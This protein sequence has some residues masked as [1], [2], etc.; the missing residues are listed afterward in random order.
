[1]I[2]YCFCC[3]SL[4]LLM[5]ML[6]WFQ[7]TL[8][9]SVVK[10]LLF[11]LL[12]VIFCKYSDV[13]KAARFPEPAIYSCDLENKF[14]VYPAASGTDGH[15]KYKFHMYTHSRHM[16]THSRHMYTHS[17][18]RSDGSL[19]ASE[20]LAVGISSVRDSTPA[21]LFFCS[22]LDVSQP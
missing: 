10:F 3:P 16:Y 14:I 8:W 11:K 1:M 4:L 7:N 2:C 19:V 6:I 17:R 18:M 20:S 21:G 13:I 15:C 22:Q 9:H 5:F 12:F